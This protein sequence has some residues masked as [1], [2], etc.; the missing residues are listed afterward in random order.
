MSTDELIK[1]VDT[2][3]NLLLLDKDELKKVMFGDS[4]H[5]GLAGDVH[6]IKL[7]L[8]GDPEYKKEGL[9]AKVQRHDEF[10]K[11]MQNLTMFSM[12]MISIGV[13]VGT[14]VTWVVHNAHKIKQ[15]F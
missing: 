3:I 6:T 4:G 8:I 11:K 10:Y 15:W 14:F 1:S 7:E 12:T 9:I 2:K 13:G 5:G